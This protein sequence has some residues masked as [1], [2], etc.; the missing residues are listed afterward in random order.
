MG[1]T[2]VYAD[3]YTMVGMDI[4]S[5]ELSNSVPSDLERI[6]SGFFL[7]AVTVWKKDKLWSQ[8]QIYGWVKKAENR[9]QALFYFTSYIAIS[10]MITNRK[11]RM[12]IKA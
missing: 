2:P 5:M 6:R 1:K 9:S 3:N 8:C 7:V 10:M 12:R 11:I 4:L